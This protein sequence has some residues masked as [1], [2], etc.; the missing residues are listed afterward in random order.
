ME[1]ERKIKVSLYNEEKELKFIE[2]Y[3]DLIKKIKEIFNISNSTKIHLYNIDC[4]NDKLSIENQ[5]DYE[6]CDGD[7]LGNLLFEIEIIA[8]NT[9]LNKKEENDKNTI[10]ENNEIQNISNQKEKDKTSLNDKEKRTTISYTNNFDNDNLFENKSEI[11]NIQKPDHNNFSF[12]D[13]DN[14]LTDF[15]NMGNEELINEI[16][17]QFDEKFQSI[18]NNFKE[19]IDLKFNE[20]SRNFE[21]KMDLIINTISNNKNSLSITTT[22]NSGKNFLIKKHNNES[23]TIFQ[24]SEMNKSNSLNNISGNPN[25]KTNNFKCEIILR[26]NNYEFKENQLE[27]QFIYIEIKNIGNKLLPKNFYIKSEENQFISIYEEKNQYIKPNETIKINCKI[28]FYKIEEK[29]SIKLEIGHKNNN[30]K[31]EHNNAILFIKIVKPIKNKVQKNDNKFLLMRN[32]NKN[33]LKTD[34]HDIF[35]KK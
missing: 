18:E 8:V 34:I 10:Y 4:D 16:Q 27:N 7:Y 19:Y 22:E 32:S 25:N 11:N 9:Q 12:N 17:N 31:F 3:D 20:I 15:N 26:K 24:K 28:S 23:F 29:I 35:N 30:Y 13:F 6:L 5:K 1:Y 2:K 33:S 14:I 21:N